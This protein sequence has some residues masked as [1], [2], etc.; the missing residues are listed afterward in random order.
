MVAV[1]GSG[2]GAPAKLSGWIPAAAFAQNNTLTG[3]RCV[4]NET[5]P[6]ERRD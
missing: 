4:H 1:P 6:Q 3:P 2:E 5:K